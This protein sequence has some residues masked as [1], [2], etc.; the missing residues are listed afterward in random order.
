MVD[1]EFIYKG[2][3]WLSL[4]LSLSLSLYRA[5]KELIRSIHCIMRPQDI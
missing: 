3:P 2:R 1:E 5:F 4:S